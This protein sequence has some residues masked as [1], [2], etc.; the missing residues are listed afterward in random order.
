[1]TIKMATT[2]GMVLRSFSSILSL[3][4][5]T[6]AAFCLCMTPRG[7]PLT[8]CRPQ[9][10]C[11]VDFFFIFIFYYSN[12]GHV[13][14]VFFTQWL[15]IEPEQVQMYKNKINTGQPVM[16]WRTYHGMETS[17]S[18]NHV[19]LDSGCVFLHAKVQMY[20]LSRLCASIAVISSPHLHQGPPSD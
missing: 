7:P 10:L 20:V 3:L 13:V 17:Y 8:S 12:S 14:I 2:P 9:L 19:R 16:E 5:I 4:S 18:K 6:L 15:S 11:I 1:M